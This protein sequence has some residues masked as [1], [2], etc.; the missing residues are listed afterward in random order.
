[1]CAMSRAAT[2]ATLLCALIFLPYATLH[3][4]SLKRVM[5]LD[6]KNLDKNP[7]YSYLEESIT[8]AIRNEL[9]AKFDFREFPQKDW[10]N[11]AEKNFFLWPEENHSRG[12][13]LNLGLLARQDIAVG[14]YYQAIIE[15]KARRGA[16]VIR[17]HVF[18]LDIGKRKVVSE[19]DMVM[20]A[21]ASLFGAVEEIAARVVKE[22]KS[23]LPNKGDAG[24]QQ[25]D[26]GDIGPHELTIAGGMAFYSLP[27]AFTGNYTGSTVLY[28]KDF[29]DT[30]AGS[31]AYTYRDFLFRNAQIE[32][33]AGGQFGSNDLSVANDTKRIKASLTV[34]AAGGHL[35]YRFS[36]WRFFLTPF[37]GG[38]FSLASVK[39][40]YSTLTKLPLDAFG[41]ELSSSNLNISAPFAE[42]GLHLGI[43]MTSRVALQFT[44]N[45]RQSIYLTESNGQL[46]VLGGLN[47]RF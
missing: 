37:A 23:V 27:A 25:F 5:I 26:D 1:M 19:F 20:P 47:F 31:V 7:D 22:S 2:V 45:Y 36:F 35:G 14:G 34:L 41:N 13:A 16:Y 24:K 3:A 43:Q 21:D 40:D 46:M 17:A 33:L 30:V 8:E 12:F 10:R 28:A 44:G 42:G 4:Q 18:V 32:L 29:K 9:K 6:F 38:G 39:L 15:K 11:L